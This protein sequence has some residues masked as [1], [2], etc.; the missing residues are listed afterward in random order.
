MTVAGRADRPANDLFILDPTAGAQREMTANRDATVA[1]GKLGVKELILLAT[2]L[3]LLS[4]IT[5]AT[6]LSHFVIALRS[7]CATQPIL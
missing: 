4:V 2:H 1:G 7:L 6:L 5:L 3:S